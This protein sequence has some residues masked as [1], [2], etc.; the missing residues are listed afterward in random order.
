MDL[1]REVRGSAARATRPRPIPDFS[2]ERGSSL[3]VANRQ[4]VYPLVAPE[5]A[6]R[7]THTY[8]S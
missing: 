3:S 8:A 4:M 2:P 6:K 1:Y 7:K 5:T